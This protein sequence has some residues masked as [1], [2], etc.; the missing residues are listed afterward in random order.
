MQDEEKRALRTLKRIASGGDHGPVADTDAVDGLQ[1][2]GLIQ[3]QEGR[4]G[5]TSLGLTALRRHLAGA[6]GF[7]AQHQSRV[8]V[9]IEDPH[10]GRATVTMN[11]DESPLAR[12]V[13]TRG[14]DGRPLI[15]AA[16]FAAGDGCGASSH[17]DS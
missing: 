2:R 16:E 15:G 7:A 4:L 9:G 8:K 5:L 1:R 17:G 6:D 12:L 14:R 11:E 3:R 10:L 13:R